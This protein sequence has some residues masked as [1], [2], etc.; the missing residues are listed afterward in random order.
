MD[1]YM[2][3]EQLITCFQTIGDDKKLTQR[4]VDGCHF[5]SFIS[6]NRDNFKKYVNACRNATTKVELN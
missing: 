6:R 5:L 4:I 2:P 3:K 1:N